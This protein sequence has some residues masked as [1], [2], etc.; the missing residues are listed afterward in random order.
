MKFSI[1]T[2]L[3]A[4]LA[5]VAAMPMDHKKAE[6][7][8]KI[9]ENVKEVHHLPSR[10]KPVHKTPAHRPAAKI[11]EDLEEFVECPHCKS[12]SCHSH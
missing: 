4:L 10:R 3:F 5:V 9:E 8:A 11:A 6:D 2:L 7:V 1:L 12:N